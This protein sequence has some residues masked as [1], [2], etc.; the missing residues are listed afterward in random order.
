VLAE[1]PF[2]SV[3]LIA[4]VYKKFELKGVVTVRFVAGPLNDR[5]FVAVRFV[6]NPLPSKLV[7][8]NCTVMLFVLMVTPVGELAVNVNVGDGWNIFVPLG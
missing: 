2:A 4:A 6:A 8:V 3:T 7:A 5:P 1:L